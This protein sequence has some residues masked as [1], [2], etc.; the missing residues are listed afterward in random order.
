MYGG[1]ERT[2]NEIY[3][4]SIDQLSISIDQLS[5]SIDQL[6]ISIDQLSISIDRLSISIDLT[7]FLFMVIWSQAY[8]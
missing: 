5:I 2:S 3:F 1:W 6:S 7:Q 4:F 8:G